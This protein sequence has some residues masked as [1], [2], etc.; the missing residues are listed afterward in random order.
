[1]SNGIIDIEDFE[2]SKDTDWKLNVL[3][4][5]LVLNIE[6]I[7]KRFESGN[8]RFE[9]LEKRKL[10]DR[11]YSFAGGIIGGILAAFSIKRGGT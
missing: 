9:K 5:T 1:M 3:F 2:K 11:I 6:K 7:D 10:A 4:K 8:V